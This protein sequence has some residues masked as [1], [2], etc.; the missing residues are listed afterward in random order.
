[1]FQLDLFSPQRLS[2]RSLQTAIE[3]LDLSGAAEK[4]AEYQKVWGDDGLTWEPD[5]LIFFDGRLLSLELDAAV[6][7]WEEFTGNPVFSRLGPGERESIRRSYF[8]RFLQ[9]LPEDYGLRSPGGVS[10]G[11]LWF[12]AGRQDLASRLLEQE[13]GRYGDDTR[14]RIRLGN[15]HFAA[16]RIAVARDHYRDALLAGLPADCW[17]EI[18]DPEVRR[19]ISA[20]GDGGW[21]AVEACLD[22]MFRVDRFSDTESMTAWMNRRWQP[23]PCDR[24]RS[25]P[26]DSSRFYVCLVLSANKPVC[27][28]LLLRDA[29][30]VMKKLNPRFHARYMAGLEDRE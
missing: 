20:A 24:G 11:Y 9:A 22:G 6:V 27:P 2:L 7:I 18:S 15:S 16:G 10:V 13:I 5:V 25:E 28:E 8:S 19:S 26:Q 23:D 3:E 21:A 17:E 1:M 14:T 30:L 4:L 12:L 29:R